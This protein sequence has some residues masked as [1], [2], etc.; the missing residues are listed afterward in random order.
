MLGGPK[1]YIERRGGIKAHATREAH[2]QT[3]DPV[4]TIGL[5]IAKS[6]FYLIGADKRG[7]IV[8]RSRVSRHQLFVGLPIFV[9]VLSR[10]LALARITSSSSSRASHGGDARLVA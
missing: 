6:T 5:D 8:M 1:A 3:S 9:P 2:R 10:G 4:T 7:S